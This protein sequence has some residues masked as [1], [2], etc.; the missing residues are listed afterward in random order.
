MKYLHFIVLLNCSF[1]SISVLHVPYSNDLLRV[2]DELSDAELPNLA[3]VKD[4]SFNII[5][6]AVIL[7]YCSHQH[8]TC[9]INSI[10]LFVWTDH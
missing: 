9:S 8:W 1:K 2:S 10:K 7:Q 5:K 4:F 6:I 3:S